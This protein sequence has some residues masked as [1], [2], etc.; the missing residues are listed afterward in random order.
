MHTTAGS[1]ALLN[2]V[3]PRDAT[4]VQNLRYK[5]AIILAKA[6]LTEF[7][8]FKGQI[9]LGW[10]AI[11]GQTRSAYTAT[12]SVGGSS[13]GSAVGVSAGFA[14]GA[15][16]TETAGSIME[17]SAKAAAYGIK[18][19]V[20]LIPRTGIVPLTITADSVGP[21]ARSTYD[22]AMLLGAMVGHDTEDRASKLGLDTTIQLR[23][24]NEGVLKD[25]APLP[26]NSSG[27]SPAHT[28]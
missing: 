24:R 5:G 7:A 27:G 19:S 26:L 10:S 23:S 28:C 2:S 6:N 25:I 14:A 4:A 20:G 13:S 8:N 3:P 21:I 18:A 17:P 22:V 12:E 15:I 1:Y 9:P 16:G 11:G